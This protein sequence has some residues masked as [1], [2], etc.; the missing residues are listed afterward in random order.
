MLQSKEV[1]R[2]RKERYI[3]MLPVRD[4]IPKDTHRPKMNGQKILNANGSERKRATMFILDKINF[5][6]KTI[7]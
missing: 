4:F 2:L 7:I 1:E 5:K 3:R 6:T